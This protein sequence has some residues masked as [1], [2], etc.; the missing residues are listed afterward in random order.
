M[1]TVNCEDWQLSTVDEAMESIGFVKDEGRSSSSGSHYWWGDDTERKAYLY[2]NI[3]QSNPKFEY[4]VT[5]Q[6]M[7][8]DVLVEIG[9]NAFKICYEPLA[10][11][12]IAIGFSINA[13]TPIYAIFVAPKT[14]DDSWLFVP[15]IYGYRRVIDYSRNAY[16]DYGASILYTN[17]GNYSNDVQIVALYNGERFYDNLFITVLQPQLPMYGSVRVEIGDKTF[18]LIHLE[19]NAD[20][21]NYYAVEVDE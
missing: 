14:Q 3:R 9:Q 13:T 20:D 21:F 12:G 19:F 18:L 5:V 10:N 8:G 1:I 7:S 11:G 16:I 6:G 15:Y 4:G 17:L 2:Y